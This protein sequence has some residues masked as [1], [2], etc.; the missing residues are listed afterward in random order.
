MVTLGCDKEN[1]KP[2]TELEKLPPITQEGK[3]TFGCLVNGKAWLPETSIDVVAV[4][5]SGVLSISGD[6]SIVDFQEIGMSLI[7][8]DTPFTVDEYSLILPPYQ[9]ARV[10]FSENCHYESDVTL[11]GKLIISKFDKVNYIISGLFE[12]TTATPNCDTL[13]VTNGRFDIKY[14]P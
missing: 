12:F 5:Q 9:N 6:N 7:E 4:Y 1:P 3:N 14:I 8:Q 10:I 2:K 13:N 11:S